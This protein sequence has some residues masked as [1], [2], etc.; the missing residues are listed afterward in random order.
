M[1]W[2]SVSGLGEG[3]QAQDRLEGIK[4]QMR[5][6]RKA[7]R[8]FVKT[9]TWPG[10]CQWG[11]EIANQASHVHG[12]TFS[13]CPVSP[14][15]L[16]SFLFHRA[17]SLTRGLSNNSTISSWQ[18]KAWSYEF[19][20]GDKLG[21]WFK[22]S[23]KEGMLQEGDFRTP[24]TGTVRFTNLVGRSLP[25][26]WNSRFLPLQG[27]RTIWGDG[28]GFTSKLTFSSLC[29]KLS[30]CNSSAFYKERGGSLS[31]GTSGF[32][33][34]WEQVGVLLSWLRMNTA[35]LE[36]IALCPH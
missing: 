28:S 16:P 12:R 19:F 32:W 18:R 2:E 33:T 4:Y 25:L 24:L 30:V 36:L 27:H 11:R 35:S 9:T 3:I 22:A 15:S 23:V 31:W 34:T 14:S 7:E 29:W 13:L 10:I 5:Q 6:T 20:H 8:V 1:A 17:H 21:F 26:K